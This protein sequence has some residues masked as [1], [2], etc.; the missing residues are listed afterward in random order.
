MVHVHM[1]LDAVAELA[2]VTL[3]EDVHGYRAEF[4]SLVDRA[5]EIRGR[6]P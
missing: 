4:V 6:M 1:T 2:S 3:G 5:I